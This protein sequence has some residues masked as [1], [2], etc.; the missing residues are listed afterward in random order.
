MVA[1]NQ[2]SQRK[3]RICLCRIEACAETCCTRFGLIEHRRTHFYSEVICDAPPLP[4]SCRL[5]S[6]VLDWLRQCIRSRRGPD[7]AHHPWIYNSGLGQRCADGQCPEWDRRNGSISIRLRP[8][9]SLR[10]LCEAEGAPS[11]VSR[12]VR[13]RAGMLTLLRG[14]EVKISTLDVRS[15]GKGVKN[16]THSTPSPWSVAQGRLL[17][18]KTQ[19]GWRTLGF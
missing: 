12:V 17:S 18:H 9:S 8:S 15:Q 7:W 1:A 10:L 5:V 4:H 13:D 11:L 2:V 3:I 14:K 19:E 16:P 6:P